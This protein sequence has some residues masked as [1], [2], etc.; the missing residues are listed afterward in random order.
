MK[1][2]SIFSKTL[3]AALVAAQLLS[4]PTRTSASKQADPFPTYPSL[5]SNVD[6]WKKVYSLYST[7]QVI[8]HDRRDLDIIYEIIPLKDPRSAGAGRTNDVKVKRIKKKYEQLLKGLAKGRAPASDEE[9]RVHALFLE[10][11]SR[12]LLKDAHL[13]VRMQLGQKDR[14]RNGVIR[15][16]A[17]LDE[18][19]RIFREYGL[20]EDL[21]YIPHVES[22]FDYEAYSKFGASGIWQFTRGTGK[23]FLAIDYTVD[24]RRDPIAATHAAAKLL[25]ENYDVLGNWPMAITAYNHGTNGMLRAK[26]SKGDYE[27]VLKHYDSPSFGFASRNFYSEFLAAREIAKN[28]QRYF[29]DLALAEPFRRH[30]LTIPGYT[31]VHELARLFQVDEQTLRQYN[32]SLREPVFKGQKYV[33]K[34]FL[35][36]L[37]ERPASG[38][39][40]TAEVPAS[41]IKSRQKP[42]RFYRV[43]RGDTVS[44]IAKQHG[45]NPKD[46]I[47]ANGLNARAT[48]YAGQNLR[49]PALGEEIVVASA[50]DSRPAP[51]ATPTL[52]EPKEIP[53]KQPAAS[54]PPVKS[55]PPAETPGP[56]PVPKPVPVPAPPAVP[57][58]E[59]VA[60]AEPPNPASADNSLEPLEEALQVNPAVVVGNFSVEKVLTR[61]GRS[62]GVIQ[63]EPE[64][65]LGHYA[66]WLQIP[67]QKIR[68]LNRLSFKRSIHMGQKIE[69]P[70]GK[71]T[72]EQF[73]ENR[74]EYHKEIEE[75]FFAAYAVDR[76]MTYRIAQG[77]NIW[78][79]CRE[80]FDLP[81][82][83]LKKYNPEMDFSHLIPS[84]PLVIPLVSRIGEES[85]P[86]VPK[87]NGDEGSELNDGSDA[88]PATCLVPGAAGQPTPS[89]AAN[90][91][92]GGKE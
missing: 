70:F 89:K 81:F 60:K 35:L 75:D 6:F 59:P 3:F 72:R 87:G 51:V 11:S 52:S 42:S 17:Y 47:L 55:P 76:L 1:S 71:I 22:S 88:D 85:G 73:E 62:Y 24:E 64:E 2:T 65:T 14:F 63:V 23:R 82:W 29:G 90:R 58:P 37:P 27:S 8:L 10:K 38:P 61:N 66:D 5:Q 43:R 92:D 80:K 40:Y 49:I 46:L 39:A 69:I 31:P 45:V 91:Q 86:T 26:R 67:T 34:G 9:K 79:L 4:G 20:P 19:K 15:S 12:R 36:H 48:I 18:I 28:Y 57:V 84:Q 32:P 50:S 21:A 54:S 16:G 74:Y 25:K 83:L 13:N 30:S 44:E 7:S 33:P 78:T 56:A 41:M 53:A 68:N 77:D